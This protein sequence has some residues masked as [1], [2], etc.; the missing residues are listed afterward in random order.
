MTNIKKKRTDY[1]ANIIRH[2]FSISIRSKS[3]N[4]NN[5]IDGL[6]IF[7][8]HVQDIYDGETSVIEINVNNMSI[9]HHAEKIER[10]SIVNYYSS[11]NR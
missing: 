6:N 2:L 11:L 4:N 10:S 5:K 1:I 8:L 7:L 9:T 3:I